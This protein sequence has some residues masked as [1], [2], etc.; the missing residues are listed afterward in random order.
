MFHELSLKDSSFS[1]AGA[2]VLLFFDMTKFFGT[3]FSKKC[4]LTL[5]PDLLNPLFEGIAVADRAVLHF[6]A[7]VTDGVRTVTQQFG[8]LCGTGDTEQDQQIFFVP[9][10][11]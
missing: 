11:R 3:F 5:F 9:A 10:L 2:K 7:V 1:K 8:N 6:H 4:F